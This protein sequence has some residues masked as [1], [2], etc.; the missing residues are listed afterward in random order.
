MV[1]IAIRHAAQINACD[2]TVRQGGNS[3]GKSEPTEGT[4]RSQLGRCDPR[5]TLGVD[6]GLACT[7]AKE[8]RRQKST[9]FPSPRKLDRG[10]TPRLYAHR[11]AGVD[12]DTGHSCQRT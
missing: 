4:G 10:A 6:F 1:K 3:N 2:E 5:H 8:S 7:T 11:T 12:V 9:R